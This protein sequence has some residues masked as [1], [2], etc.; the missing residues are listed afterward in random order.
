MF[1]S[2]MKRP[3]VFSPSQDERTT[4]AASL[5]SGMYLQICFVTT[6][7]LL[8]LYRLSQQFLLHI[9]FAEAAPVEPSHFG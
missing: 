5:D 3:I 6:H 2:V 9:L 8:V 1:D 7:E 4:V